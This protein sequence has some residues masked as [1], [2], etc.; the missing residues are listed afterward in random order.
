MIWL[1][2]AGM[3][4]TAIGFV[5]MPLIRRAEDG[6]GRG[7]FDAAVYRDQLA[8]IERDVGRG[9]LGRGEADAARVEVE[10]RLL[11]AADL[12]LP[13][14][15]AAPPRRRGRATAIALGV[16]VPAMAAVLYLALGSPLVPGAPFA[17]RE[18]ERAM[19]AG[20]ANK[21]QF[22]ALAARLAK[23][24][25]TSPDEL[26]GWR[27]LARSY[28]TLERFDDAA[29]AY[30][31]AIAL[32]KG[33]PK[34]SAV[35]SAAYGEVLVMA[36]DGMVTPKARAAFTQAV[37][38]DAANPMARYYLGLALYQQGNTSAALVI[39][40][41]LARAA[42]AAAPWLGPLRQRIQRIAK[43]AGI[44][45]AAARP[46]PPQNPGKDKEE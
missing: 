46:K 16:A 43:D 15:A 37:A 29:K 2:L 41:E 4:V 19:A 30:R 6:P 44:D 33:E 3:T 34:I 18:A 40:I 9:L 45:P 8:E 21:A 17:A 11:A 27:L 20:Q 25:E 24:L 12:D 36:A 22:E 39:W 10:R 23:R 1:V 28:K 5:L 14:A 26:E 42:P 35:L 32:V 31:R 38:K 13:V 7:A